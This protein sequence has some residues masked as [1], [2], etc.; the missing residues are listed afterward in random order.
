LSCLALPAARPYGDWLDGIACHSLAQLRGLPRKGL[1]Q[2][3][4]PL[5]LQELDQA[6]GDG[7]TNLPWFQA[8]ERFKQR[9]D[10]TENLEH[11]NAILAVARRLIEQLCGWLHARQCAA[12]V[13]DLLLHHEKGRHA[14]PPT[15]IVLR[16]SEDAWTP[17]S[18]LAVL[19]EQLQSLSLEAPVIALELSVTQTLSRPAS[20]LSLFP[21]PEQW[22]RQEHRVLDLL[23]ARLGRDRVLRPRPHADHRPEQANLW[24]TADVPDQAAGMPPALPGSARPFWLLPEPEKLDIRND[25]PVYKHS[26]LRLILGPER[27]ETGWWEASGHEQRD[28]FVAQDEQGARYWVYRQR[29]DVGLGWFLHGFFG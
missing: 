29:E 25:R 14:R 22:L 19:G 26:G 27:L 2:R 6:Y 23:Q 21:E 16:L 3:S 15:R 9:Y 10:L 13:L 4:S 20:S 8:P 12:R 17:A 7:R 18:F 28:Y 1:Q 5:L 11:C 24:E